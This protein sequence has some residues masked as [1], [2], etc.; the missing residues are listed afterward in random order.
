MQLAYRGNKCT[1][2]KDKGPTRS[3]N[4]RDNINGTEL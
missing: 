3:S 4:V 2:G 1:A